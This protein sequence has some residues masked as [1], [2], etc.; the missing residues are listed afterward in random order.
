MNVSGV[1]FDMDGLIFDT[2]KLYYK[3]T[4]IIADRMQIPYNKE[5]YLRF[6]G[7]SD[8]EVWENYHKLYADFGKETV[9]L[10]I[11]DSYA[12]TKNMFEAGEAELKPGVHAVINYLK[13]EKIPKMLASSNN[14]EL[15]NL[16]LT[17]GGLLHEFDDI[18]SFEDVDRAKPDP[19]I[20]EVAVERLGTKKEETLVLED[21]DNGVVAASRANIPVIMIPDMIAPSEELR[22]KTF[23]VLDSLAEVP[24]FL[25]K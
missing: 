8:D 17:K 12:E 14:R 13:E 20:F 3:G 6:L 5:I 10:F 2:E 16:L 24:S 19:E 7:M 15:I 25:K 18:V 1:I 23:A 9:D 22:A 4:Q 21:S 11:K